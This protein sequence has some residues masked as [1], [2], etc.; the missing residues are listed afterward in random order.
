MT[1]WSSFIRT[2]LEVFGDALSED[3]LSESFETAFRDCCLL[4]LFVLTR[5]VL[6]L[7]PVCGGH[8]LLNW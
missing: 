7:L 4:A 5:S 8:V 3:F 1:V 2:I 6:F